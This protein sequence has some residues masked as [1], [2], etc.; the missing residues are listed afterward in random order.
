[1]PSTTTDWVL[2]LRRGPVPVCNERVVELAPSL[3]AA[4]VEIE[5]DD[6]CP[7]GVFR[8]SAAIDISAED[9]HRRAAFEAIERY[10]LGAIGWH[11]RRMRPVAELPKKDVLQ[12]EFEMSDPFRPDPAAGAALPAISCE[13]G[14]S[15]KWARCGDVFAPFPIAR[16]ESSLPPSTNGAALGPNEASARERAVSELLERD[17]VMSFWFRDGAASGRRFS[18]SF[19]YTCATSQVGFLHSLGYE[20]MVLEIG[21]FNGAPVALAFARQRDGYFPYAACA[22]SIGSAQQSVSSATNELVQTIVACAS[23]SDAYPKWKAMGMPLS[24]LEHNMWWY[25]TPEV[26]A[27][28]LESLWSSWESFDPANEEGGAADALDVVRAAGIKCHTVD[29]TPLPL[30]GEVACV[31]AL[32]DDLLPLVVSETHGPHELVAH[33]ARPT[34]PHPFP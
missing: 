21:R 26:A 32:S 24:S 20:T 31:R 17:A 19:T 25:A 18:R 14:A 22:A 30:S 16:R 29:V 5:A 8:V 2:S 9:A 1:M 28:A 10:C 12:L 7:N 3:H 34:A 33:P 15:S 11:E 6:Y 13:L 23:V 4:Y 27:P